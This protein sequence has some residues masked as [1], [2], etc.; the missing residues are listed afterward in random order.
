MN[1][2]TL[3]W[4]RPGAFIAGEVSGTIQ[5]PTAREETRHENAGSQKVA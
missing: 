5:P 3:P 2:M 1:L 4:N